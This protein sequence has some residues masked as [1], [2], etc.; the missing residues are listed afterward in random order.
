M[1]IAQQYEQKTNYAHVTLSTAQHIMH[2]LLGV[3][4]PSTSGAKA[5]SRIKSKKS[6]V[7]TASE[8]KDSAKRKP[9]PLQERVD[10]A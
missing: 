7:K 9:A 8:N 6:S 3:D 4:E 10:W 5:I 2:V 1:N